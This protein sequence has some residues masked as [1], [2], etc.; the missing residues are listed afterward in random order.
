MRPDEPNVLNLESCFNVKAK[1]GENRPSFE[2]F[3]VGCWSFLKSPFRLF[4]PSVTDGV[5]L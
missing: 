5:S 2:F 3:R 4:N 1:K